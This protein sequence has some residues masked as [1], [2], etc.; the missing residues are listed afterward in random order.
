MCDVVCLSNGEELE[1]VRDFE[2]YFKVDSEPLKMD[3]YSELPKDCCLCALDLDKFFKGKPRFNY[4]AGDWI[5]TKKK[6]E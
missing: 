6:E 3:Y 1:T 5:E 2:E 4:D